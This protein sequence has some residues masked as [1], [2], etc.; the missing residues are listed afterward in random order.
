M[1]LKVAAGDQK[2]LGSRIGTKKK[3]QLIKLYHRI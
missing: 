1:S 3:Y 2:V